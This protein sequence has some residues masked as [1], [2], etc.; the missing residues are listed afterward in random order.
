MNIG[1]PR[2]IKTAERR[3]AVTPYGVEKLVG[4]GHQVFIESGAGIGS[5]FTDFQYSSAGAHVVPV[6]K[7]WQQKLIVKVKEP[8][9]PE[10]DRMQ[11]GQVLFTYLHLAS[12]KELT[13]KLLKKNIVA[14]G[15]ETIQLEDGSLPL[16]APMSQVAGRLAPQFGARCLESVN[17]GKGILLGGVPGIGCARVLILGA[18]VAGTHAA[19]IA[20]GMGAWVTAMDINKD[21]LNR[22]QAQVPVHIV[23]STPEDLKREIADADLVISTI[24]IP[25]AKAPKL[26]TREMLRTM[27]KGSAFVDVAIDQGGSAETSRPTTLTEPM[28]IEE[29]IVHCC[30]ANMP[31]AVPRVSTLA[32]TN[33]TLPYILELAESPF[34]PP[35]RALWKG[36]NVFCGAL[37]IREVADAHGMDMY[38]REGLH[39]A[40]P[41]VEEKNRIEVETSLCPHCYEQ[42]HNHIEWDELC[43]ECKE[44]NWHLKDRL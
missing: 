10:F 1:V 27:E 13:L 38:G 2:E 15:Y 21:K 33:A 8:L 25:G 35:N 41:W 40:P 19:I 28:Y 20:D 16:L 17:G 29:G 30:V 36:M 18:G 22:L 32:L 43:E 5:G 31:G 24:L 23:L 39:K 9:G 14:Y 6:E 37:G 34:N 7:V 26:I 42:C 12:S 3:V 11:D 4:A 44:K